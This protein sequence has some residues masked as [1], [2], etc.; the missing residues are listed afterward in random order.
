MLLSNNVIRVADCAECIAAGWGQECHHTALAAVI[1]NLY[2]DLIAFPALW[3]AHR[4]NLF[5]LDAADTAAG[6]LT[7]LLDDYLD[8][9]TGSDATD[10]LS[11]LAEDYLLWQINDPLPALVAEQAVDDPGRG[12]GSMTAC[13]PTQRLPTILVQLSLPRARRRP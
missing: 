2:R 1:A 8:T 7:T 5:T 11:M 12:E 10:S 4:R 3:P 9:P 6:E 13:S